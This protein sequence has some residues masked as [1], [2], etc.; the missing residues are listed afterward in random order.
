[1]LDGGDGDGDGGSYCGFFG[2][3]VDVIIWAIIGDEPR[4]GVKIDITID[5]LNCS[6]MFYLIYEVIYRGVRDVI[7]RLK[8]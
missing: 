5:E 6:L 7:I 2:N 8:F 1:M 4:P 3:N